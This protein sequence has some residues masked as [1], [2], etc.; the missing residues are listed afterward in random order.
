MALRRNPFFPLFLYLVL[1]LCIGAADYGLTVYGLSIG[2]SERN[3]IYLEMPYL[4]SVLLV[5]Y[6]VVLFG[7]GKVWCLSS[8]SAFFMVL[9]LWVAFLILLAN[10]V[11][12][13]ALID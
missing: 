9:M 6:G 11:H 1:A 4:A 5:V 13:F 3:S 7:L 2:L 12:I 8:L 10:V